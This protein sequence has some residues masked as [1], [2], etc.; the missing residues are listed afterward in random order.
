MYRIQLLGQTE[1]CHKREN[2][3]FITVYDFV[4][5]SL[6]YLLTDNE[7][8]LLH[9]LS[10]SPGVFQPSLSPLKAPGYLGERLPRL[11]SAL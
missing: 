2:H 9:I 3:S 5:N 10:R 11:S 6:S 7:C 4:H 8:D 1:Q